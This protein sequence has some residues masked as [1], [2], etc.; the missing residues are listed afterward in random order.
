[1]FLLLAC[2]IHFEYPNNQ[3]APVTFKYI[4]VKTVEFQTPRCQ[5]PENS[6]HNALVPIV[7]TYSGTK[8]K[9]VNFLYHTRTYLINLVENTLNLFFFLLS[10]QMFKLR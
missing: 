9:R 7:V 3:T 10:R 8:V 5:L 2:E 6:N 1:M 4:D